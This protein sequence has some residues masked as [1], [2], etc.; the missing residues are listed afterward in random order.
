MS[1]EMEIVRRCV[2]CDTPLEFKVNS[3]LMAFTEHD[4]SFCRGAMLGKI[5]ALEHAIKS[6]IEVTTD[7]VLRLGYG[8]GRSDG[9]RGR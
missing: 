9:E 3:V 8:R 4:D 1:D 2:F 6:H 7:T 5:R